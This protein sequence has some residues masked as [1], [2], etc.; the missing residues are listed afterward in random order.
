[1]DKRGDWTADTSPFMAIFII[2]CSGLFMLFLFS[3]SGY[4]TDL[5]KIRP[6][7]EELIF[8]E[9]FLKNCFAQQDLL[10][11]VNSEIDWDKFNLN[12][13]DK[14]YEILP[15]SRYLGFRL[16][17]KVGGEEKQIQTINWQDKVARGES[18]S[19]LVWKDSIKKQGQLLI[20][21]QDI[22]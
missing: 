1:M 16:T 22:G 11:G 15:D 7:T 5:Y 9:R 20:E 6:G 10:S 19:V 2:I 14:C 8:Q 13:L 4:A 3:V 18:K 17:L 21:V 12:H